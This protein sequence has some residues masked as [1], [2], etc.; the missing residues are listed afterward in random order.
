[1]LMVG[2]GL[3]GLVAGVVAAKN[4][5]FPLIVGGFLIALAGVVIPA[6]V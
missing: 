4:A 6:G 3:F 1:M 2:L 5:G